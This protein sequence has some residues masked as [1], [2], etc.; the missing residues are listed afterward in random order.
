[1][2]VVTVY[3]SVFIYVFNDTLGDSDFMVLC[4]TIISEQ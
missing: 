2:T 4:C 3:V 1:M